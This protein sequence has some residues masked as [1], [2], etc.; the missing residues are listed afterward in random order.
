MIENNRDEDLCRKWDAFADED[1][2]HHLTQ[3]EYSLYKSNWWLHSNKQGG[4]NTV[5]TT[6]R[7]DFKKA[8]STLQQ[9]KQKEEGALQRPTNSD[10][11]RQWALS[12][13]SWWNWQG[14]WWTPYSYDKYCLLAQRETMDV[15]IS[16]SVDQERA[17]MCLWLRNHLL[18]LTFC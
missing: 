7:S 8:L 15:Q 16:V 11:N 1:H 5:R 2:T 10:R 18:E 12:S 17:L 9:L 4:S 14:S 3:Q 6:H 13:S